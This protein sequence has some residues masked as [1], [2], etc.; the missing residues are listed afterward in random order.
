[1]EWFNRA[2]VLDVRIT[3]SKRELLV[4]PLPKNRS[5]LHACLFECFYPIHLPAD[6]FPSSPRYHYENDLIVQVGLLWY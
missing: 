5:C 6:H 1:M 2:V 4:L 3:V